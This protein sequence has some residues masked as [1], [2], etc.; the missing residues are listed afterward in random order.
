MEIKISVIVPVYNVEKYIFTCLNSLLKQSLTDIEILCIDDCS[1]D[2][3]PEILNYFH[4]KDNRIKIIKN[5]E[6]S[7]LGFSRNVGIKNA[8]GKYIYF[9]DSDDWLEENSLE[10]LYYN[11]EKF[12]ADITIFKL[13]NYDDNLK[14]F[15][16]TNYYSMNYME[17]RYEKVFSP[18]SLGGDLILRLPNSA[19]NKL[20]KRSLI[21][22]NNIDFPVGLIHEDN[23]FFFKTMFQADSIIILDEYFYNRRIRSNSITQS[24]GRK[25]MDMIEISDIS[26]SF[27]LEND[28]LYNKYK[29]NILNY[30]INVIKNKFYNIDEKFE[31]E[32][33]ILMKTKL[34]KYIK[35]YNLSND[36][37]DNLTNLNKIFLNLVLS[38]KDLKSFKDTILKN[39]QKSNNY[40]I[41]IIIPLYNAKREHVLRMFNSIRKQSIGFKNLEVI[42]IDDFSTIKDGLNYVKELNDLYPNVILLKQE[43]NMGSGIA[44]NRGIENASS[45]YIMFLDHDDYYLND[46]CKLLYDTIKSNNLDLV[47]G[48]YIDNF[49]SHKK[50]NWNNRDIKSTL[51]IYNSVFDNIK[52]LQIAPSIWTKIF[53]KSFL[54]N[55]NIKF[56]SFKAGQDLIFYQESIF[57][58]NKI[59]FLDKAIVKYNVRDTNENEEGS[60][61]L[62]NSIFILKVLIEVYEY[63]YKLFKKFDKQHKYIALNF[64]NYWTESRLLHSNLS[65]E[66]FQDVL[67]KSQFM[68]NEFSKDKKVQINNNLYN[69]QKYIINKEYDKAYVIYKSF[70]QKGENYV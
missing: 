50:I 25:L 67:L 68:F 29:K 15:Y 70:I 41:S 32:Y 49:R 54:I 13:I 12:N 40:L 28:E 57:N 11:A 18:D 3:S 51:S 35:K 55:N 4:Q 7:G 63:S 21:E 26:L 9:I 69:L 24:N 31:E 6:N 52:V 58:A 43:K 37:E 17:N 1:T 48:N 60:I 16:K 14:K 36:F 30:V 8:V 62:N 19:C 42:I 46:S 53:K 20:Y 2:S 33:Y 47:S 23:P 66:E 34:N 61:S 39:K 64:L 5:K 45:D 22:T 44:R 10:K 56:K 27:F 59:G 65:Y 38:S